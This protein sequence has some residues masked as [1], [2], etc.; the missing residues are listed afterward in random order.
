[1][2][3]KIKHLEHDFLPWLSQ[4]MQ[5]IHEH[6]TDSSAKSAVSVNCDGCQICCCNSNVQVTDEE[7]EN[8]VLQADHRGSFSDGGYWVIPKDE[9]NR[10]I[11][12]VETGCGIFDDRPS[13]CRVFDCRKR[14][15][16]NM[17]DPFTLE[18]AEQWDMSP[19]YTEENRL[20]ISAIRNT[21][22]AYHEAKPKANISEITAYAIMNWGEF[23]GPV[24]E[25]M[26]DLD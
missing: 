9:D 13:T 20:F 25:A 15:V 23:V 16:A 19:W 21:A 10:C 8:P 14:I 4:V 1:M 6:S 11:H 5:V 24:W 26:K 2:S 3:I 12:L 22:L 17:V 18:M 7:A